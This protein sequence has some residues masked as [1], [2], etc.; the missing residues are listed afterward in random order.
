MNGLPAVEI[1]GVN[2][3]Q[4][5]TS[6]HAVAIRVVPPQKKLIVNYVWQAILHDYNT[7]CYI[8]VHVLHRV[9]GGHIQYKVLHP[10]QGVTFARC[11]IQYK[12]LHLHQVLI[13]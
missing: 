4:G 11:F 10:E 3:V 1:L 7:K 8:Q 6:L 5:V 13:C 12:V 9:K 2:T